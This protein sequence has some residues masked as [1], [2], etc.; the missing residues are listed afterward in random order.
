[1]INELKVKLEF[2]EKE[3]QRQ[4]EVSKIK[5]NNL[6]NIIEQV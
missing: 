3:K 2:A 1:L 4:E 6:E 5:I